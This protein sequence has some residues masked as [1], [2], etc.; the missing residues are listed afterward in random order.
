MIDPLRGMA[1]RSPGYY[2]LALHTTPRLAPP[3]CG[4]V[5]S[6]EALLEAWDA[7]AGTPSPWRF[8]VGLQRLGLEV[9]SAP[10]DLPAGRVGAEPMPALPEGATVAWSASE[11]VDRLGLA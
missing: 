1:A 5:A 9:V 6:R 8:W 3:P 2:N 4:W 7:V 10:V 11:W